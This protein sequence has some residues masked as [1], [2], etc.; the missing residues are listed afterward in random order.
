MNIAR[1]RMIKSI[2]KVFEAATKKGSNIP[3]TTKSETES[4][5]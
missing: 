2:I 5:V 4:A 3:A 1:E